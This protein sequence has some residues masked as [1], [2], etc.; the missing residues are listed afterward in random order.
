MLSALYCGRVLPPPAASAAVI[1]A[2]QKQH[3]YLWIYGSRMRARC[4]TRQSH[5]V[6]SIGQAS[7]VVGHRRP[8]PDEQGTARPHECSSGQSSNASNA[9]GHHACCNGNVERTGHRYI[10]H[11]TGRDETSRMRRTGQQN[12]ER[13]ETCRPKGHAERRAGAGP[14]S[15]AS[16]IVHARC[17]SVQIHT[18]LGSM[19]ALSISCW[20]N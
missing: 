3:T 12:K 5:V 8:Q 11:K 2:K 1:A 13:H 20:I 14:A 7:R 15:A 10:R 19:N 4:T 17:L 18:Y 9:C 16:A 6:V